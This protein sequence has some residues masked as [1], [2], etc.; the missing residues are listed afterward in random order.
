ML[1][2]TADAKYQALR[3][4]ATLLVGLYRLTARLYKALQGSARGNYQGTQR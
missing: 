1:V 2:S 3:F 4:G